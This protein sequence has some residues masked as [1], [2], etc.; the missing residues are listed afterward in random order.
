VKPDG[1]RTADR[2]RDLAII[3]A[4]PAPPDAK[5]PPETVRQAIVFRLCPNRARARAF[6]S[7]IGAGRRVRNR[8]VEINDRLHAREGRFAVRAELSAPPPLMKRAQGPDRLRQPP[9]IHPVDV[10]RR[11][12]AAPRRVPEDRRRVKAGRLSRAKAAGFPGFKTKRQGE[13]SIHLSGQ[14]IAPIRRAA[15]GERAR[16]WVE[17][18]GLDETVVWTKT[19]K[20]GKTTEKAVPLRRAVRIRGG[21]RPEGRIRSATIRR[22]GGRWY[23]SVRFDG[24]PPMP[25]RKARPAAPAGRVVHPHPAGTTARRSTT[26]R[27]RRCRRSATTSA[28]ATWRWAPTATGSRPAAT[29]ARRSGACAGGSAPRRGAS[30]PGRGAKRRSKRSFRDP[31]ARRRPTPG[32]PRRTVRSGAGGPI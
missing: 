12:D 14:S 22:D 26:P 7:W 6:R 8:R 15:A 19:G 9:T 21:R 28:A 2:R 3:A 29:C 31:G 5:E 1:L 4:F 13:G 27:R 24:P 32:W 16:D 10:S 20:R 17:I 18:P 25:R 23:L 11:D 30:R